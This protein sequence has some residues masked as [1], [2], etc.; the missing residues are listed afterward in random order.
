[1]QCELID[2]VSTSD[3][4][5][6]PASAL[7]EQVRELFQRAQA[8]HQCSNVDGVAEIMKIHRATAYKMLQP[9][10]RIN[11]HHLIAL[12][13]AAQ[14]RPEEITDLKGLYEQAYPVV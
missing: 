12:A 8:I 11:Y 5:T 10:K 13:S 14:L 9:G 1:M 6:S 4:D 7:K 2:D 3:T